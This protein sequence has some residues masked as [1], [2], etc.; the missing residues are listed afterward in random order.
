MP[1]R[2]VVALAVEGVELLDL[3]GPLEVFSAADRLLGTSAGGYRLL[4]AG[5]QPGPV[6][7]AGGVRVVADVGWDQL[8]Q[9][10]DTLLV[11]G[12]LDS[13]TRAVAARVDP[14]L[15]DWLRHK[16]I[17]ARRIASVC[18]GAHVLAA[19]GLLDGRRATTHWATAAALATS[20][21]QV[22]VTPDAVFVQDGAVW[23]SA[24]VS[25]GIDLALAL[26]AEDHGE[27]LARDLARWLVMYLKRPGGQSQFSAALSVDTA[28]RPA[29][30]TLQEWLPDHL[31]GDLSLAALAARAGVSVRT[32]SRSFQSEVGVP[33]A[34][35]VER[36]RVEAAGRRLIELDETLPAIARACG[37]G[38]VESLHRAFRSRLGVS[39]AAYRSRFRSPSQT[40]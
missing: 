17:Q 14:G 34:E 19:A 13:T 40:S 29:L 31:Q 28:R 20:F 22:A 15:V 37:F 16:P 27:R 4:V 6:T 35:Y 38:S 12:A 33:P 36:L 32:L 8:V 5:S 10:V 18:A 3:T 26:V 1:V 30:R 25:T 11:A 23:T 24:G 7:C 9:P 21:P 2:T 39:P